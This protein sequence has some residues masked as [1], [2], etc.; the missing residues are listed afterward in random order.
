MEDAHADDF[1]MLNPFPMLDA[2]TVILKGELIASVYP[3]SL[4]Y[5]RHL[6]DTEGIVGAVNLTERDWPDGW[7]EDAGVTYLHIPVPNLQP[8]SSSQTEEGIAFIDRMR[9]Q[10][11]VLVHCAAGIGRTGTLISQYLVH[12]GMG[13]E[14]AIALVRSRRPGSVETDIQVASVMEFG[15]RAQQRM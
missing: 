8:P 12:R 14:E 15:R 5:L 10:G 13:G 2:Y 9:E 11:P 3:L 7:A 4:S 6:V 1:D